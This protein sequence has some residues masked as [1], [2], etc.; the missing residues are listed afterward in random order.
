MWTRG[1]CILYTE[2]D[3]SFLSVPLFLYFSFSSF[4]KHEMFCDIFHRIYEAY[5]V[6]TW[7]M[8]G[9][10]KYIQIRLLLLICLFISSFFL[11]SNFETLKFFITFVSGNVRPTKLKHG[12]HLNN[13]W[14]YRH[15]TSTHCSHAYHVLTLLVRIWTMGGCIVT[16]HP[17]IV[18]M[19]TMF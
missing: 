12:T 17:P 11:F 7:T 16:I 15:D 10:I 3:C 5:K 1:G 9:C 6:E 14:M 8:C 13:G 18:H 2:S 19:R 4:L